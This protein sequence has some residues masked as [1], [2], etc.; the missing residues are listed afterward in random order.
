MAET[1]IPVRLL[2]RE[3]SKWIIIP[4]IWTNTQDIG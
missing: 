2:L 3:P 4:E 1:H